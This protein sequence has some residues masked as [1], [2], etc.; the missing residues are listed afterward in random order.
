MPGPRTA[1]RCARVPNPARQPDRISS[2]IRFP[3]RKSPCTRRDGDG[4]GRC[5]SS[6]RNAHSNVAVVSPMSSSRCRH[7]V[8][9]STSVR[10]SPSGSER[11]MAA[12]A[13]AHC[14]SS[15]SRPGSSRAR[16]IF[17]TIVS[18]PMAS[19]MRYGLPSAA[20]EL[21]AAR[22]CGTGAPAAAARCWTAASSSIPACTSSGGPVRRISDLTG[23]PP[24]ADSAWRR[25]S[26]AHVV[27]LAPPVKACRFSTLTS[28]R[29]GRST[30]A[31]CSFTS[32]RIR[33]AAGLPGGSGS[34]LRP[35]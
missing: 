4:A 29:T 19:Q 8:S 32:A 27:R 2:T 35:R 5:A 25:A 15:R 31:S 20:G 21:S 12:S 1:R 22:M 9:W 28:P 14:C 17:L 30:A 6:Q 11:W 10:P 23:S 24:E 13:C 34:P 18:P 33:T 16:W 3:I 26:N 7:S